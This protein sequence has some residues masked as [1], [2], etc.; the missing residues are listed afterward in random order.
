MCNSKIKKFTTCGHVLINIADHHWEICY[1]GTR[2]PF[3]VL[4]EGYHVVEGRC[5]ACVEAWVRAV[6]AREQ[7][8]RG[9]W[10]A[11]EGLG[12]KTGGHVKGDVGR[13]AGRVEGE[14]LR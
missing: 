2:C 11:N 10:K 3:A 14:R 9:P 6:D 5:P 8:Q 12:G 7:E 4:S 13:N 1:R